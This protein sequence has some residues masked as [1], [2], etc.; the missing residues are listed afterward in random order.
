MEA[1]AI[2]LMANVYVFK[3]G[4]RF[5]ESYND[6]YALPRR[7]SKQSTSTASLK[8][9]KGFLGTGASVVDRILGRLII[10]WNG[11][12]EGRGHQPLS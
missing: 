11:S 1:I 10:A 8:G 7:N 6:N 12:G 3:I 5:L 2:K 9:N 4:G